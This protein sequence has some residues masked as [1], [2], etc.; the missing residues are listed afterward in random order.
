GSDGGFGDSGYGFPMEKEYS[1]K[2]AEEIDREIKA[3]TKETFQ[4]SKDLIQAN[5]DNLENIAQA[6]LKYETLDAEEVKTIMSGLPLDKPTVSD[7]LAAEQAKTSP[8]P[9]E[10]NESDGSDE[11][12][13][14]EA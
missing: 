2:T 13:E 7:L 1:E 3:L 14:P 11:P 10:P 9:S 5:R 6:L 8:S 4:Q 12:N